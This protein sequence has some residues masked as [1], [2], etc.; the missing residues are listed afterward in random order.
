MNECLASLN[1][2]QKL[3]DFVQSNPQFT[4][5]Q[6]RGL[7]FNRKKNGLNEH[8]RKIGKFLYLNSPGFLSWIEH[9]ENR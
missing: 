3:D 5:P 1:D 9:Y 8:T 6:M 2:W 4:V 7:L